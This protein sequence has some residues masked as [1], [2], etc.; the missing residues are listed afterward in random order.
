[1]PI[2]KRVFCPLVLVAP[3]FLCLIV[4][5]TEA[6][7]GPDELLVGGMTLTSYSAINSL[8]PLP[9]FPNQKFCS[10]VTLAPNTVVWAYVPTANERNGNFSAFTGKLIDPVNNTQFPLNIIPPNR[11]PQLFAWR[12]APSGPAARG[13]HA[14]SFRARFLLDGSA[15]Y[16]RS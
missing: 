11:Q 7:N 13:S 4:T 16:K 12:L 2:T 5:P 10:L 8:I 9:A 14:C 15:T 3:I 1:M 6:Q